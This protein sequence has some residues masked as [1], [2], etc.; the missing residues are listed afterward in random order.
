M[1]TWFSLTPEQR[2]VA[3]NQYRNLQRIPPEQREA[4]RQK[5]NTYQE[6]PSE[7]KQRFTQAAKKHRQSLP[8][9]KSAPRQS[10]H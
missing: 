1:E 4:L 9:R 8:Y 2:A 10:S 3:R 7:E 6:L 5:W